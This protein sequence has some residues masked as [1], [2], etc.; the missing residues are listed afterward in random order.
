MAAAIAAAAVA[1]AVPAQA[2]AQQNPAYPGSTLS[3]ALQGASVEDGVTTIVASG[4]NTDYD[5]GT[6]SLSMYAKDPRRDPTCSPTQGGEYQTFLNNYPHNY[7]IAAGE[8]ES[9]GAGSFTIPIKATFEDAGPL[10]VCAYTNYI[11][12]TAVAAQ[13]RIEVAPAAGAAPTPPP[14]AAGSEPQNVTKP[15]VVK[16]KRKLVC[17]PGAWTGASAYAYQWIIDGRGAAE[18]RALKITRKLRGSRV[19]CQVTATNPSGVATALSRAK[20]VR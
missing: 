16:R 14:A 18:R 20:R 12:E 2:Q 13:L 5:S 11:A 9:Y 19:R 15:S 7:A 10:L 3:L 4:A 1:G 8:M 17:E 6:Y